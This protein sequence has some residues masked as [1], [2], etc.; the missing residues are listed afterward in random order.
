[1]VKLN[2]YFF[3]VPFSNDTLGLVLVPEEYKVIVPESYWLTTLESPVLMGV[4][5]SDVLS[6]NSHMINVW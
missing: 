6:F 1:M 5:E 3:A 2:D 4:D